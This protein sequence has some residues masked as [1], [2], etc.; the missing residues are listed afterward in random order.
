MAS[1]FLA[2]KAGAASIYAVGTHPL[3]IK[4]AVFKL[5]NAGVTEIIGTDTLSSIAMQASMAEIIADAIQ[6]NN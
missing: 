1:N 4:N 3:L 5:L 6:N 2:K